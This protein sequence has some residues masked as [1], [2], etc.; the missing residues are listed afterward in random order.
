MQ[1]YEV[2]VAALSFHGNE[3]LTYGSE[4]TLLP[5]QMVRI[6]L[7]ERSTL[8]IVLR[9]V[10][11]PR[12]EVK[13]LSA[14]APFPP[15]PQESLQLITWLRAYYPAT[16]GAV[17]RQF[18]PP[19]ELFPK[20]APVAPPITV[21][22]AS[23]PPLSADQAEA[24]RRI[25]GAGTF[26]LHGITGSGKSRVYVELAA[27]ALSSN[28]SALIL[29]PEIGLTAQLTASFRSVFGK[30]V[31]VLHSRLTA[32]E[33]R[34][35]WY[36]LLARTGPAIVIG[37]R[38]ALF[39]PLKNLGVIALDES[40]DNA[41]KNESAPHYHAARVAAKL[42]SLHGATLVLGSA[43]PNIEDYF[44]AKQKDRPI[45]NML[46]LAKRGHESRGGCPCQI[47]SDGPVAAF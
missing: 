13:P 6:S 5:G 47:V 17:V 39:S 36:E 8:G 22:L 7:R 34:N 32:A 29:T 25:D 28:K 3:A 43:T 20:S 24:L 12:F 30:A 44:L 10:N 19:T 26:L 27:R 14:V 16:L 4:T 46:S 45:I 37:P 31:Y 1:Y 18:V 9:A 11:K 15:L 40:H 23:L 38:S 33:R 21:D 35:I 41:Y 42:A 2:Y